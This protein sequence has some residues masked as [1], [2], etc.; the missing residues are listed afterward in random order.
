ML[1]RKGGGLAKALAM[2]SYAF[3][4]GNGCRIQD[5]MRSKVVAP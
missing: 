2:Y 5:S 4:M 3:V 1:K